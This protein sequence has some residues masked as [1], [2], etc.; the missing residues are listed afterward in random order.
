MKDLPEEL[1]Q[2]IFAFYDNTD[3]KSFSV[4]VRTSNLQ[5]LYLLR[6]MRSPILQNVAL[7]LQSL[8]RAC[9]QNQ[10]HMVQFLAQFVTIDDMETHNP[11]AFH[12]ICSRRYSS[13]TD[14][15]L[16]FF[17]M[18]DDDCHDANN[19]LRMACSDHSGSGY[20]EAVCSMDSDENL[21][22]YP[23]CML[24]QLEVIR[25]MVHDHE[26]SEPR[27]NAP[28]DEQMTDC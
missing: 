7:M 28:C 11:D 9:Y 12:R 21:D 5:A 6:T 26:D 3:E 17:K 27:S 1:I 23:K 18:I 2:S 25:R 8:R 4:L 13:V 10:T 14:L 16:R 15:F 19:A 22:F 20:I 24:T